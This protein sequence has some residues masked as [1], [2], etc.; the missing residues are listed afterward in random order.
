MEHTDSRAYIQSLLAD[1]EFSRNVEAASAAHQWLM[2]PNA[3][4]SWA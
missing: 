1:T 3:N 2:K 4:P